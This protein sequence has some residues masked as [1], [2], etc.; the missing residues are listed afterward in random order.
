MINRLKN[1]GTILAITSCFV[2][3]LNTNGIL[4]DSEKI[5]VTISALCS[6]GI[7][8]GFLNNP[9]TPGVDFP[10]LDSSKKEGEE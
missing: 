6:I 10:F 1:A 2:L 4:V 9:N 7:L 5:E 3:I 8:L